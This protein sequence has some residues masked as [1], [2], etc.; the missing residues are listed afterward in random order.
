VAAFSG[1]VDSTFTIWRHKTRAAGQR[2]FDLR[3]CIMVHGFDIPLWKDEVFRR[4]F[5]RCEETLRTLDLVLYPMRTNCRTVFTQNWEIWHGPAVAA[6]LQ[7]FKGVCEV[8]LIGSTYDSKQLTFPW[9]SNPVT[10]PLF[11]TDGFEIIHDGIAYPRIKKIT[12]IMKW[13]AG[14][15]S[16]RVCFSGIEEGIIEE[17]N[18]GKCPRCV[19]TLI[20]IQFAGLPIPGSFPGPLSAKDVLRLRPSGFYAHFWRY[21]LKEAL[22]KRQRLVLILAIAW[23]SFSSSLA[24]IMKKALQAAGIWEPSFN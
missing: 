2:S 20:R 4:I 11:A 6:C 1:G 14:Y 16:L 8:G 12:A 21:L 10:D 19:I 17:G 23:M 22:V 24:L 18:C 13:E 9:G 15:N 3:C 5:T 7:M